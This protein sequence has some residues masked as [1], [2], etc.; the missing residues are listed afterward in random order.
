MTAEIIFWTSVF[1]ILYA[2]AGYPFLITLLSLFAKNASTIRESKPFV[3][4][5]ITAYNEEKD[6]RAKIENSL[7][8][9]Y[10]R[11]RLEIIVAS[12]GSTDGTDA[13]VR[14]YASPAR[15]IPVI[16]HRV[17]GRLGKTAAQ[18]SAVKIAHGE[19]IVFSDAAS[20]Y[21]PCAIRWLVRHYAD[22][23]VGAVSGRYQYVNK[24]RASV[25]FGTILFWNIENFIKS[26]QARLRTMTGCSGCIYSVRKDLYTDLPPHI[27]SDLVE[28]LAI[29][30]KGYRIA[31]EPRALAFEKTTEKPADEFMMRV[32]VIVRGMNGLLYMKSL[33]NPFRFPFVAFQLFSHKIV[34]WMVPIFCVLAFVSSFVL[35]KKHPFYLAAFLAQCLFYVMAA[36]G[37]L[38]EKKGVRLKLFYL[39]LY[40]ILVNAASLV[41]M[42]KVLK[43][44]HIVVWQTQR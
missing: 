38:F 18:N 11:Q 22:P 43:G 19:I 4:L 17:E 34:R 35:V 42:V 25:G 31:F 2:Y 12:D 14:E 8:L 21:E 40:F 15:G 24:T 5:L 10:P 37:F 33:L 23:T 32:R 6:I 41:S 7:A 16:L 27:I 13:I 30:K 36:G 3:T 29:L 1:F 20:L 26:R 44:E 28:P 39:P 9:E